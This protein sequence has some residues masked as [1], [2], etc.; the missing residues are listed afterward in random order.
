MALAPEDEPY[1]PIP[2]ANATIAR[3]TLVHLDHIVRLIGVD[4]V[5][6][7]LDLDMRSPGYAD[8]YREIVAGLL[9]RGYSREQV[10]RIVGGNFLRYFREVAG[11]AK[12]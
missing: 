2:R 8:L 4:H 5:A 6:V 10:R 9:E 11:Q 12:R 7:G 1:L 3:I